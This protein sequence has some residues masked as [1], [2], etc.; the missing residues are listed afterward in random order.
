MSSSGGVLPMSVRVSESGTE[1][2]GNRLRRRFTIVHSATCRELEQT[3]SLLNRNARERFP[4][5]ITTHSAVKTWLKHGSFDN[6]AASLTLGKLTFTAD[7]HSHFAR[8]LRRFSA[9]LGEQLHIA[10]RPLDSL[11][12]PRSW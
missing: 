1:D 2:G 8:F 3:Q 11:A 9:T 6:A 5:H 7:P 12:T 4:L 10:E